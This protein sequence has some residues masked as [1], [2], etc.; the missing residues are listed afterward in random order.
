M[1]EEEEDNSNLNIFDELIGHIEI[2]NQLFS[3]RKQKDK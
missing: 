2:S 3:G 1:M